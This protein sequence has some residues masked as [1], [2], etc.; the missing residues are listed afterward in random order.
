MGHCPH[1][2]FQWQIHVIV[3]DPSSWKGLLRA[4][5]SSATDAISLIMGRC[6]P[7]GDTQGAERQRVRQ[8]L[9]VILDN[10]E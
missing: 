8:S 6:Q 2:K 4:A 3:M 5:V 9:P 1:D 7:R 10:L